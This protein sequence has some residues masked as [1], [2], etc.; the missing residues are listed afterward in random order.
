MAATPKTPAEQDAWKLATIAELGLY[1]FWL[2][3]PEKGQ[4]ALL[5]IKA[6]VQGFDRAELLRNISRVC[7]EAAEAEE[8]AAKQ[9]KAKV[10]EEAPPAPP[11]TMPVVSG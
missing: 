9:A 2:R 10:I 1:P 8:Q 11:P 4:V 5:L 6:T 3:D 7:H